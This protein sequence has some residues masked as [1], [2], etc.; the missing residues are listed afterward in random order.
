[1]RLNDISMIDPLNDHHCPLMVPLRHYSPFY[2]SS[3]CLS[4]VPASAV[5]VSVFGCPQ[6]SL[7]PGPVGCCAVVPEVRPWVRSGRKLEV[8]QAGN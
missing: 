5:E 8:D 1:M 7:L 2:S 3:S 6:K 4:S